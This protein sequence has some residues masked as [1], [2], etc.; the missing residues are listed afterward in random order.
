MH[1][2]WVAG[3]DR[4]RARSGHKATCRG[5]WH[6]ERC[7]ALRCAISAAPLPRRPRPPSSPLWGCGN[8][9][10]ASYVPHPPLPLHWLV[11]TSTRCVLRRPRLTPPWPRPSP[12]GNKGTAI[13][14]I[15]PDEEQYSP[16][17]IKALSESGAVIPQ[18]GWQ[19]PRGS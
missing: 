15:G 18:V 10:I 1:C 7:D 13:T 3:G 6:A 11:L 19:G 12:A 2:L 4:S 5:R 17:L 14:F 8:V 16:D 9:Y